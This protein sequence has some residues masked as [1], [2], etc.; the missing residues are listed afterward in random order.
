MQDKAKKAPAKEQRSDERQAQIERAYAG[1]AELIATCNVPLS[2]R[3]D[4]P[5][6]PSELPDTPERWI[7][8]YA[9]GMANALGNGPKVTQQEAIAGI[10]AAFEKKYGMTPEAYAESFVPVPEHHPEHDKD[11]EGFRFAVKKAASHE[12]DRGQQRE[13]DRDKDRS[14]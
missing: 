13:H 10:R 2:K 8:S 12:A 1:I 9:E 6:L 4:L 11:K 3:T 7:S 5:Y 14:R